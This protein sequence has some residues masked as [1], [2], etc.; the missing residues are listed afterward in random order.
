MI[1]SWFSH[2]FSKSNKVQGIM[3]KA[4]LFDL[5]C[6]LLDK[7]VAYLLMLFSGTQVVQVVWLFIMVYFQKLQ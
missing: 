6:L 1:K 5:P 4:S 7:S 2:A 3:T